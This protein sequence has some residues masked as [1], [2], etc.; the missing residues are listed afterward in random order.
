[1]DDIKDIFKWI[2]FGL[3][4]LVGI[5]LIGLLIY[6][7]IQE[8][9]AWQRYKVDHNCRR[10]QYK[11]SYSYVDYIDAKGNPH[12]TYVPSESTYLCDNE[13]TIIRNYE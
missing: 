13:E 2:G 11:P 4:G 5:G 8:E 7:G 3:L 10:I 12:T 6:A 9:K 1:M